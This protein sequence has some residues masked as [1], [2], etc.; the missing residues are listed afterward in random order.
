[1]TER[2][3]AI[4]V[5][6]GH[7]GLVCAAMLAQSGKR[8]LVL[9][10]ANRVGGLAVTEEFHD[11]FWVSTGAHLVHQLQPSVLKAIGV[12]VPT[13]SD[14]LST[15][16]LA[17]DGHHVQF[18]DDDV[19]GAASGET[20]AYRDFRQLGLRLA[21][22]LNKQ[23]LKRPPRFDGEMK[24]LLKLGLQLRLLGK[25]D[26]RE[27]LR[28]VGQNMHD[29]V[30]ARFSHPLLKA[31][32][33]LDAVTGSHMGPRSPGTVV[34]WLHRLA[35]QDGLVS[36]PAGGV[37]AISESLAA[38][39]VKLG[40]DIRTGHPVKRI[41]V[42]NGRVAGVEC[43]GE[44]FD[45]WTVLSNAD[46]KT[47]VQQLVGERHFEAPYL[48]R[49]DHYRS[50]GNVAKLHLALDGLPDVPGLRDS[51]L[52]SRLLIAPSE[53]AIETAF[54]PAK[55]GA[56]SDEPV[57]EISIPS[58]ADDRCAPEGQHV[59]SAI[60]QFAPYDLEGGWTDDARDRFTDICLR[61]LTRYF[62]GIDNRIVAL[63][64][65]TPLDIEQRFG[66]YGGHWH[67][68]EIALDQFMFTRPVVGAAQYRQPLDGLYFCGAGAHPGGGIS[69]AAGYNAAQVILERERRR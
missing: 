60:V 45:S 27:L 37:G 64:L 51:D 44:R 69:G 38:R 47:T 26:M 43:A 22:F 5:G 24:R 56:F 68:G 41:V 65:M 8:V 13:V 2:Y 18:F 46:P 50:K 34:A 36:Q 6:A 63:E 21:R 15:I 33:C 61:T 16:V 35:G 32:I 58:V 53:D 14:K 1:M 48:R 10:A 7:N 59:L 42:D 28:L 4:V 31:A 62:P 19:A 49:I 66:N 17:E 52:A 23:F 3:D 11:G 29:E 25:H 67:H 40:V 54:D 55:Y 57:M 30:N 9:E 39:C 12:R 20:H